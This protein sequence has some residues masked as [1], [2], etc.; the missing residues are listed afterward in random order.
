MRLVVLAALLAGPA[1]RAQGPAVEPAPGAPGFLTVLSMPAASVKLDGV[2]AGRTPLKKR[3]TSPGHHVVEVTAPGSRGVTRTVEV[4]RGVETALAEQLWPQAGAVQLA[5][6]Q[7]DAKLFVDGKPVE[8]G[9][10]ENLP[11]GPHAVAARLAGWRSAEQSVNVVDQQTAVVTLVL[12]EPAILVVRPTLN[13]KCTVDA[14]DAQPAGPTKPLTLEVDAGRHALAC[15]RPGTGGYSGSVDLAPSQRVE[16][17]VHL[18]R[19][20]HEPP[21]AL[22]H[23]RQ[24]RKRDV[25]EAE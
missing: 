13:A 18:S 22:P 6:S 8:A 17:P 4:G 16:V 7:S 24:N 3:P 21:R 12:K 11:A 1:A 9:L 2:D 20:R 15:E 5:A 23:P 10:V 25:L 19:E 14:D